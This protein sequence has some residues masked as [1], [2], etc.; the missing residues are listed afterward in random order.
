MNTGKS[1]SNVRS[2][3][4]RGY[5][6]S[7]TRIRCINYNITTWKCNTVICNTVVILEWSFLRD[8]I[9]FELCRCIFLPT[10]RNVK[11]N[12]SR[13]YAYLMWQKNV[14][15][16]IIVIENLETYRYCVN[17]NKTID[18]NAGESAMTVLS[19]GSIFDVWETGQ[20]SCEDCC[21]SRN[22]INSAH[23]LCSS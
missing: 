4:T 12:L 22:R 2:C 17:R 18:V 7:F 6:I 11:G 13:A 5:I 3:R 19:V 20:R 1:K 9:R 23:Y 8:R 16:L 15:Y 14:T 10:K 21:R